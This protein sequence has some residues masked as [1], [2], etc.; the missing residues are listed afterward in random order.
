[1][2]IRNHCYLVSGGVYGQLGNVWMVSHE[3]GCVL[4]DCGAP[5]SYETIVENLAYWGI[6][7]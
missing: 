7:T 1:M 6:Y 4:F 3:E 5:A 2:K